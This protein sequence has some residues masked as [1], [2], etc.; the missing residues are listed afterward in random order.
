MNILSNLDRDRSYPQF[1]LP[2]ALSEHFVEFRQVILLER[3]IGCRRDASP[4]DRSVKPRIFVISRKTHLV[5]F[6]VKLPNEVLQLRSITLISCCQAV[7]MEER[8][9]LF[10]SLSNLYR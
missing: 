7:A 8:T 3:Y 5:K 6:E 9:N 10:I 1:T 2:Q 4:C